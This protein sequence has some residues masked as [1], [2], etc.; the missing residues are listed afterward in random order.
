MVAFRIAYKAEGVRKA[1]EY[2]IEKPITSIDSQVLYS[3]I[4]EFREDDSNKELLKSFVE[5][6]V[7][8]LVGFDELD[9]SRPK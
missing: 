5:S 8:K 7:Q 2:Y 9:T 3:C 6:N 1:L 4:E